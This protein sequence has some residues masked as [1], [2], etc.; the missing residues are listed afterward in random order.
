LVLPEDKL[1]F[2]DHIKYLRDSY[3]LC[4]IPHLLN[5]SQTNAPNGTYCAAI[6]FD[7]GFRILMG[8]CLEILAK[9]DVQATFCVPTGFVELADKPASAARFSRRAHPHLSVPL[10]PMQPDDLRTLVRLGHELGSHG[11]SHASVRLMSD[12]M[13]RR[14]LEVSQSKLHE[15]TGRKPR[16]FAYPYG[17]LSNPVTDPATLVRAAGYE[18]GMTLQRG[19]VEVSTNPMVLPR[20]HVEGNWPVSDLRYF[21]SR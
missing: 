9:H 8:S 18:S 17:H 12:H 1:A 13:L 4:S 19:R 3:E 15:W 2:E 11:V 16:T 14:E 20:E 10:L 21:L 6:T 5:A 7:D